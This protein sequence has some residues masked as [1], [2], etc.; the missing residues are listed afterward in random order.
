MDDEHPASRHKDPCLN[1]DLRALKPVFML[2][3]VE[4]QLHGAKRQPK[5]CKACQVETMGRSRALGQEAKQHEACKRSDG[6]VHEEYPASVEAVGQP[7]A[8][9]WA[10]NRADHDTA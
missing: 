5:K 8:K 9:D 1:P 2:A 4:H 3:A 7:S 10:Q 6:D